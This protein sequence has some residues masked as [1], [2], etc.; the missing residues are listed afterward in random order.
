MDENEAG[1]ETLRGLLRSEGYQFVEAAD[2]PAALQLAA[3]A[4]PDLVLLDA[5]L[6]GMD[7]FEVCRR[8]RADLST[9][10][11]PVVM[12]GGFNDHASRVTAI[13]AGADNVVSKPI[14]PAE[15]RALVRTITRLNRCGRIREADER[16]REQAELLELS[17][18]AIIVCDPGQRIT[19]WNA[20]AVR[21]YGWS[22]AEAIG[23]RADVLLFRGE[24]ADAP[25][26]EPL[27]DDDWRGEL[28]QVTRDEKEITVDSRRKLLRDASGRPTAILTINT[29]LTGRKQLEAHF[30]RA[31][32]LE[33]IGT[34]AS[35]TAHDL[36]NVL[37]SSL[38][39]ISGL[40]A[41]LT[42]QDD[43]ALI[44][45]LEASTYSG[46]WLVKQLLGLA[47]GRS[48]ERPS[49]PASAGDTPQD[50][51]R[52]GTKQVLVADDD[53]SIL[54]IVGA[55]L[56][57]R[58]YHVLSASDGVG[59]LEVF[60]AHR[61]SIRLVI[62][63]GMMPRLNGMMLARTIHELSPEVPVIL[64]TGLRDQALPDDGSIAELLR[65]PFTTDGLLQAVCRVM[66]SRKRG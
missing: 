44:D 14:D 8:L 18:D 47:E 41:R 21:L 58:G 10:A 61:D 65:K 51:P 24:T 2:G 13:E 48:E 19:C 27:P 50:A 36:N 29:D 49:H 17:P 35:G 15:F 59:A 16:I 64:M 9:A 4:H 52:G 7:G 1:R 37:A 28:T 3:D 25:E 11:M 56:K 66:D 34:L 39:S 40:R 46:T 30:V 33:S 55:I 38:M 23:Q 12:I 26:L 60:K 5:V 53:D 42:E 32:R 31:Q 6:P 45:M 22:A 20:A 63:D 43:K 62:T 54:V 57:D